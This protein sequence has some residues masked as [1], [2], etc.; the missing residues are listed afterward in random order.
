MKKIFLLLVV[1]LSGCFHQN[2][3]K[4][5]ILKATQYCKD[6]LGIKHITVYAIGHVLTT[7]VNGDYINLDEITLKIQE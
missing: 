3:D 6:R 5:D 4:T 2:A 7:C 1:C